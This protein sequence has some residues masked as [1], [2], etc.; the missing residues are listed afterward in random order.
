MA[1]DPQ[2]NPAKRSSR[3]VRRFVRSFA[4]KH[5][6]IFLREVANLREDG[7]ARF[8]RRY[9]PD[10][11]RYEKSELFQLRDELRALWT[12]GKQLPESIAS[13]W[14]EDR[15]DETGT[16]LEDFICNLW[17]R[18]G[19]GLL[20]RWGEILP[21]DEP[22]ALLAFASVFWH[23]QMRVC[24]NPDCPARYFIAGRH[25]QKYCSDVC[26]AP[27]KRAAK[28]RSWHKNKRKWPSQRAKSSRR[29]K[30]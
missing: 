29:T 17:L 21:T 10:F 26:A 25:D 28:L 15:A 3:F 19:R 16:L 6:P 20:V 5:A 8:Q 4:D 1:V 23:S 2:R 30:R 11:D 24:R 13:V 7:I 12:H 22:P 14:D 9:H 27:A 18:R